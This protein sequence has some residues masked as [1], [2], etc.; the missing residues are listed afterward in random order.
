MTDA[1]FTTVGPR[2]YYAIISHGVITTLS[3]VQGTDKSP[4]KNLLNNTKLRT[5]F[6]IEKQN[7]NIAA[8]ICYLL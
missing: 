4:R 2:S 5:Y 1:A 7:L 8:K 3:S 6:V